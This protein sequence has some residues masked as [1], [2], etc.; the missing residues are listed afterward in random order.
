[1]SLGLPVGAVM[2]CADNTG[3]KNLYIISVKRACPLPRPAMTAPAHPGHC[4]SACSFLRARMARSAGAGRRRQSRPGRA[5][6]WH[7]AQTAF[8]AG[9]HPAGW[10]AR[11]NRLPGASP[12]DMFM[13]TVKKGKPDLRK[14]GAPPPAPQTTA[15]PA[16]GRAAEKMTSRVCAVMPGVVVRQRKPFRRKDGLFIYFEGALRFFTSFT[17]FICKP[18]LGR[19]A[20]FAAKLPVRY[21]CFLS[22][23]FRSCRQCRRDC[24]P[25]GRDEGCALCTEGS[26]PPTHTAASLRRC[27]KCRSSPVTLRS[28]RVCL[29]VCLPAKS[30]EYVSMP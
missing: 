7:V 16:V 14:K 29:R 2:N 19:R 17:S 20:A 6:G 24:E 18:F 27:G 11:L 4:E 10:G 21:C 23:R 30:S 5:E 15:C 13:G 1:M 9:L 3:A 26:P 22:T 8:N 28:L 25:E 12:G